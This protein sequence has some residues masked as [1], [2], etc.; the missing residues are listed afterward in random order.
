MNEEIDVEVEPFGRYEEE[1]AR[2]YLNIKIASQE[3]KK[4]RMIEDI[5]AKMDTLGKGEEPL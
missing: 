1:K 4:K 3:K 5:E 2:I